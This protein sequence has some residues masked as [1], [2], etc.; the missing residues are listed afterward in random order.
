MQ[1]LHV[2]DGQQGVLVEEV[3][4]RPINPGKLGER[5]LLPVAP[6]PPRL[7]PRLAPRQAQ[8]THTRPYEEAAPPNHTRPYEEAAP[9]NHTRPYKGA[10]PPKEEEEAELDEGK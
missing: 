7:R 5:H 6:P 10:A 4:T 2:E 1:G 3:C 9:P 8:P